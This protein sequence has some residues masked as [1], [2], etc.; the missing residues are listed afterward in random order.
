M[1][2]NLRA[3]FA[4]ECLST[5]FPQILG[6]P[7]NGVRQGGVLS[8]ILFTVYV[9]DLLT[10]LENKGVGCYWNNHFVGALCYADD[11]ALL[12]PSP[13]ALRLMLDTCSSFASSRSLLFNASKTQLVRFSRTCSSHCSP[14][15]FFFNGL[16][17]NL[18]HSA[19]HLGH[20]L[21][22]NLSDADDIV[23]VKNDLVRKANCMLHSFSPC[24]PLVKTKL[25][26]SFCL[27]LYGS[28]L[29]FSSSPEL[30]SLEVSFNNILRRI[31]S[32]PRMCHTGILHCTAH[33]NSIYNIVVRRSSKLLSAALKSQS[34]VVRDVFA[35]SSTL[36]YTSQGYNLIYG[37]RHKKI[38]SDQ[39]V[40]CANFIR[41]VRLAPDDNSHLSDDIM[42]VC[43]A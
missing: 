17:L 16:E 30:R 36:T 35:Q 21:S 7:L 14:A 2:K 24:N 6:T 3:R 37:S 12:A 19:K 5:P 9:D 40:L 26:D 28:A 42:Y 33:L 39:D 18:G 32:L 43:T 41:D 8:P 31:W 23:R 10:E 38:Y 22:F 34:S 1:A 25:F 27:S 13:A 15:S 4:R 11:I 20:L 29:W